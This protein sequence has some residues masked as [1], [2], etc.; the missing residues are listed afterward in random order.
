MPKPN[1]AVIVRH[2]EHGLLEVLN[3]AKDYDPADPLV[4]EYPWAFAESP[5]QKRASVPVERAT[6]EPGERRPRR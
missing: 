6:A 3:P 1:Q 5:S 4:R 2:P